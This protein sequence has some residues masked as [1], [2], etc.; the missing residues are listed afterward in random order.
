MMHGNGKAM[1]DNQCTM[2]VLHKS[3]DIVGAARA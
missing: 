1:F 2:M 3:I